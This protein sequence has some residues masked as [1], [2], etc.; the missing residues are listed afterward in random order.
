MCRFCGGSPIMQWCDLRPSVLGQ[1]R[2]RTKK[3]GLGLDLAGL[4]LCCEIRCCQARRHNDLEGNSNFSSTIEVF[5]FCAWNITTG[6]INS[7]VY[8]LKSQIRQVPLTTSGGLGVVILVMVLVLRIWS[9]LHHCP[10][11]IDGESWN[12]EIYCIYCW[13]WRVPQLESGTADPADGVHFCCWLRGSKM[14]LVLT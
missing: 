2:S 5:L 7:G 4:V 14:K 1:H 6:E 13:K 12:P 10:D 3:I 11:D 9:C 8:L